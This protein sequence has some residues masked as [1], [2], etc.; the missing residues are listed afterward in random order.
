MFIYII[1]MPSKQS[2]QKK[3]GAKKDYTGTYRHF[4][5]NE[6]DG[7][8]VD[9]GKVD[10]KEHQ[11]P[12]SAAKK[13]YS[14]YCRSKGIKSNE[15]NKVSIS[16]TIRE[17]TRGHSKVYGPY[18]GKFIKYDKPVMVK[19]KSTGKIIKHVGKPDVRLNKSKK[20]NMKGGS[21]M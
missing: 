7:K 20:M 3:G 8:S 15:R 5:L 14:S 18:K 9:V 21:K 1:K 12:L 17:T 10:I 6:V 13:L 19:I 11:N 2:S 16:F 4:T